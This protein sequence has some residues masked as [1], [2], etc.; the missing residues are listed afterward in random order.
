M[1][2]SNFGSQVNTTSDRASSMKECSE[3]KIRKDPKDEHFLFSSRSLRIN[4]NFYHEHCYHQ[5]IS[6]II[7]HSKRLKYK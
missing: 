7:L 2:L 6:T 1:I 5:V 3:Q 4:I